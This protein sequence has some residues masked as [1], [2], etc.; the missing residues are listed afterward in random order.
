MSSGWVTII[1]AMGRGTNV[2][3][4]VGPK[5]QIPEDREAEGVEA[6][7]ATRLTRMRWESFLTLAVQVSRRSPVDAMSVHERMSTTEA[8]VGA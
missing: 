1:A 5:V 7:K 6:E 3:V 2:P 8:R 4:S